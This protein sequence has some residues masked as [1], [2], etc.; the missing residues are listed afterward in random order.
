MEA[1]TAG[2]PLGGGT[3]HD[4]PSWIS[5]PPKRPD[6]GIHQMDCK[7]GNIDSTSAWP[8]V[9][10]SDVLDRDADRGVKRARRPFDEQPDL[11]SG[12]YLEQLRPVTIF[13]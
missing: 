9:G 8:V 13:E 4:Q 1:M 2:T 12:P 10:E 7:R 6:A 11:R 3:G 5:I